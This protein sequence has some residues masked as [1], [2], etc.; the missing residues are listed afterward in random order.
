MKIRFKLSLWLIAVLAA[1]A[2]IITIVLLKQASVISYY[3]SVK[4]LGHLTSQRVEFWKGREDGYIHTLRTLANIMG[5][6]ESIQAK[7]RRDRYDDMLKSTLETESNMISLYTVWKPNAIDDMDNYFIGRTGSSPSGQYAISYF[8]E[9]GFQETGFKEV[10]SQ[11]TGFM[12]TNFR[13]NGK[14]NG[15]TSGDIESITAYLSGPNAYKDRIDNPSILK[16]KGKNTYIIKLAVPII[17]HR[18]KKVVGALGCY[19]AIDAIQQVVTHTMKTNDEIAIM[20]MYSGNGTIIAHYK[21]ERIGKRMLDVEAELGASRQDMF[22]AMQTGKPFMNTAY[23]PGLKEKVVYIMKPFQIGNS[24]HNWSMLIG[25]P[26][27]FILKEVKTITQFTITL[28]IIAFL[29]TAIIIFVIVGTVTK[30]IVKITDMLKEISEDEGDLTKFIPEKGNDEIACLSRYFN[31]TQKKIRNLVIIIKQHTAVLS[32]TENELSGN[33]SHTTEVISQIT[34]SLKNVRSR[35]ID[36]NLTTVQTTFVMEQIIS[37]I[38]K[39]KGY[40]E[41]QASNTAQSNFASIALKNESAEIENG[42]H[43]VVQESRF[44]KYVN[45]EISAGI[46]EITNGTDQINSAVTRVNEINEKNKVNINML[47]RGVSMFKVA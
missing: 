45:D 41:L 11:K 20:A 3:L 18:T 21:P 25:V 16:I 9:F 6:Y 22:R 19:L 38:D 47:A 31:L 28:V 44:L 34:N 8:K 23:H 17:N 4:S 30:P 13:G 29:I 27:S 5:D 35:L 12:E 39:L 10:V 24:S 14:I 33:M 46:K 36:M 40:V 1:V 2:I 42:G 37:N 32:D 15:R 7:E 26:E 43:E